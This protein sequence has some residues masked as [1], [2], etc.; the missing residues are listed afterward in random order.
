MLREYACNI[1][2]FWMNQHSIVTPRRPPVS[3]EARRLACYIMM[4]SIKPPI[5]VCLTRQSTQLAAC[6]P[7]PYPH[8]T[9]PHNHPRDDPPS[10]FFTFEANNQ[11][12]PR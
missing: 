8:T 3:A 1:D 6:M 11:L 4:A 12:Q 7:P 2:S 5:P 9:H 10:R